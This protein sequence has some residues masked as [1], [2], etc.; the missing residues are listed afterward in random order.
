MRLNVKCST[1]NSAIAHDT[2]AGQSMSKHPIGFKPSFPKLLILP[3]ERARHTEEP[4]GSAVDAVANVTL[5]DS[6]EIPYE[7]RGKGDGKEKE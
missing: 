6:D 7:D 3:E 4:R 5:H 2:C 1:A